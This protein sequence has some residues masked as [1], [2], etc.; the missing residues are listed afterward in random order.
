VPRIAHRDLC[1]TKIGAQHALAGTGFFYFRDHRGMSR[2]NFAAYRSDEISR[3]AGLR[4]L[5][6]D[7]CERL[8]RLSGGHFLRFDCQNFVEYVGHCHGHI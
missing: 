4:S 3:R 1:G 8:E 7:G 2:G 6:P 5:A